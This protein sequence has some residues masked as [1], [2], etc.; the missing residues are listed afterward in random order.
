MN[1]IPGISEYIGWLNSSS[2]DKD[3]MIKLMKKGTNICIIP[4]GFEEATVFEYK[5]HK[6]FIKN[7]KGKFH[8]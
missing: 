2:C 5:K 6:I 7:K 3:T 4:G 8:N 1:N